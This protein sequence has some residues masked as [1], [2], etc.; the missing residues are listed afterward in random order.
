[1][2]GGSRVSALG[3]NTYSLPTLGHGVPVEATLCFNLLDPSVRII[4]MKWVE[5]G[6]CDILSGE[7]KKKKLST[8]GAQRCQQDPGR[9]STVSH[10]GRRQWRVCLH[11]PVEGL[12][13][14]WKTFLGQGVSI[15]IIVFVVVSKNWTKKSELKLTLKIDFISFVDKDRENE[16]EKKSV[17]SPSFM[18][19]HQCGIIY[20]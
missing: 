1:M 15:N 17:V 11:P 2:V 8:V 13:C 10:G 6:K 3:G 7:G 20:I 14:H 9:R 12:R 19:T 16:K 5:N 4:H 18:C